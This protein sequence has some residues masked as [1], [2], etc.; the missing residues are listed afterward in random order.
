MYCNYIIN[1]I[2]SHIHNIYIYTYMYIY[3]ELEGNQTKYLFKNSK[4]VRKHRKKWWYLSALTNQIF[5]EI[6]IPKSLQSGHEYTPGGLGLW[7]T[8]LFPYTRSRLPLCTLSHL[9]PWNISGISL[10]QFTTILLV[11]PTCANTLDR[12]RHFELGTFLNSRHYHD[13]W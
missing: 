2:K 11:L 6:S 1:C 12:N 7:P 4:R 8:T 13:A 5:L 10:F 9:A 3:V